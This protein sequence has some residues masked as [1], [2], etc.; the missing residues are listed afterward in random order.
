MGIERD[1]KIARTS[2]GIVGYDF[3]ILSGGIRNTWDAWFCDDQAAIDQ[4]RPHYASAYIPQR[5][6][7]RLKDKLRSFKGRDHC[8][9]TATAATSLPALACLMAWHFKTNNIPGEDRDP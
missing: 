3:L 8:D 7:L 9:E 4:T 5:P 1:R 2:K 6:M